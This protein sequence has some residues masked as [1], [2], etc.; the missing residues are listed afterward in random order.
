MANTTLK[1]R[2]V[3]RNDTAANW[4]AA[5]PILLKGEFG[6][7]T[8]E[9]YLKVGDGT[10][11][12]AQLEPFNP[13]TSIHSDHAPGNAEAASCKAGTIWF[14]DS[15]GEIYFITALPGLPNSSTRVV[16]HKN[17][18]DYNYMPTTLFA[19]DAGAG[20]GTGYVDKSLKA[21]R[22]TTA[23]TLALSGDV[24][25][26]APFDGSG[27]A[28]IAAT[29]RSS[30]VA[31]GTYTKVTVDAKGIVTHAEEISADDVPEGGTNLYFTTARV[32]AVLGDPDNTFILDGGA[33]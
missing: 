13:G 15:A 18:G 24:T 6:Y 16:T 23:R 9:K 3:V 4:A 33:A 10:T 31:A 19:K 7:W 8:D 32:L 2:L 30:G 21:D 20:Q 25:G 1:A 28:T 26:S 12:W 22:L 14:D 11:H 5:D 17:I 29:L 27:N